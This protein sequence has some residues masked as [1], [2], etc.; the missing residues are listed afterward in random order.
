MRRLIPI[1]LA[2]V[3][4]V[5]PEARTELLSVVEMSNP[6]ALPQLVRGFWKLEAN[7]WRWASKH[8]RVVLQAPAGA[9]SRGATLE[10]N[11]TL[12]KD[13]MEKFLI[14]NEDI[15]LTATVNGMVLP[16][17]AFSTVGPQLFWRVVPPEAFQVQ[18]VTVD[19]EVDRALPSTP[20]DER[21]FALVISKIGLL[22]R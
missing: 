18:P 17:V 12:P 3:A 14:E 20:G 4:A 6:A 11:F 5:I 2:L 8:F 19:I 10:L 13:V 22:P 1:G 9:S 7:S 21:E 15:S 16:G